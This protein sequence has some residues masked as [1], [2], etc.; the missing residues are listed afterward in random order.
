MALGDKISNEVR[1]TAKLQRT[2]SDGP[3]YKRI[4]E[5]HDIKFREKEIDLTHQIA[6]IRKNQ[7]LEESKEAEK[8]L[9][10]TQRL[11]ALKS[12]DTSELKE[13][14]KKRMYRED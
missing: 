9:D 11:K 10:L 5:S 7:L 4:Q 8:R 14:E 13:G 6:E 1:K 12:G 3:G 2:F